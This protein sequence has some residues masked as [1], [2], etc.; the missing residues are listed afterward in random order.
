MM[1][2]KH[3]FLATF[4]ILLF[5]ICI[6]L[7]A[8]SNECEHEYDNACDTICNLCEE[9]RTIAHD[10][11]DA[12]CTAPKTCSVCGATE[13]EVLGHSYNDATCTAP[14]T[15]SVCGATEGEELGHSYNDATCIA[16][17]TCSVCGA[18]EGEPLEHEYADEYTV[19]DEGHYKH[20][21]CHPELDVAVPHVD[22]DGDTLCDDC[23]YEFNCDYTI[24]LDRAHKGVKIT[25]TSLVTNTPY[26]AFTNES[27]VALFN[28]PKGEYRV[29]VMHY[30]SAHIWRDKDNSVVLTE[31]SNAYL[32]TFDVSKESTEYTIS[33]S[34]PDGSYATDATVLVYALDGYCEGALAV[35]P[36][37][38][39]ITYLYNGDY[40][41]SIFAGGEYALVRFEKDGPTSISVVIEDTP[42]PMTE[43]NPQLI[44]DLDDLPFFDDYIQSL[45]FKNSY[46][47]EA[48]ESIYLLV[49][50]ARGKEI[51]LGT[52]KL[53]VEHAGQIIE[54]D[55]NNAFTLDIAYG[56]STV[57]KLTATEAT[58]EGIGIYQKGSPNTP[59]YINERDLDGYTYSFDFAAGESLYFQFSSNSNAH[60]T[61]YASGAEVSID[62]IITSDTD[63]TSD[64][65]DIC[66][67][68]VDAGVIDIRISYT[69]NAE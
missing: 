29:S 4:C 40:I 22:N 23:G 36:R 16:P 21:I 31:K 51:T 62:N 52:D 48:G 45:P 46:S 39:A 50:Y 14:K 17:K 9:E 44:F 25:L 33:V 64:W 42:D 12:T 53:I 65:H 18:T 49:P 43:E 59:I 8:C 61:V 57:I 34:Y 37:G 67:K 32:V 19:L 24:T 63:L 6:L 68:A 13:G 58:T 60:I 47:L 10:Y 38:N 54:L 30:N 28:L 41:A 26:E 56:E 27:G 20:C 66:V 2:T 69:P 15:C 5:A 3:S 11:K 35:N 7:T 1:N 55:E